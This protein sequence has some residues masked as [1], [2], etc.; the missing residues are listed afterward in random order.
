MIVAQGGKQDTSA[1][2]F[3]HNQRDNELYVYSPRNNICVLLICSAKCVLSELLPAVCL[4]A[5]I[6]A[7]KEVLQCSN[8]RDAIEWITD[9]FCLSGT[10]IFF[11]HMWFGLGY[12]SNL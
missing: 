5:T 12:S 9:G 11:S 3:A 4:V 6:F 8:C 2:G 7:M 1:I 10:G